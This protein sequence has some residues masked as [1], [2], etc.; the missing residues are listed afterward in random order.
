MAS[1][2]LLLL[3]PDF[4]AGR[5][6]RTLRSAAVEQRC[7]DWQACGSTT[8]A[9]LINSADKSRWADAIRAHRESAAGRILRT[10]RVAVEPLPAAARWTSATR[11]HARL[12]AD[13]RIPAAWARTPVVD[14]VEQVRGIDDAVVAGRNDIGRT[15][16]ARAPAVDHQEQV[17]GI[18][19]AI[20]SDVGGGDIAWAAAEVFG[21]VHADAVPGCV[22][23]ERIDRAY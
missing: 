14:D 17:G 19:D 18:D 4:A 9:A 13:E 2:R 8:V 10:H 20:A 6:S 16:V 11:G 21:F 3:A 5:G 7:A 23:A 1:G 12:A 22:A 15:I